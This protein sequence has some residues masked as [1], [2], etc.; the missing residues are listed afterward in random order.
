MTESIKFEI[1]GVPYTSEK[2]NVGRVIDFMKM[3]TA[4]SSGTYGLMYREALKGHDAALVMINCEAFFDVFCPKFV[5]DLKPSSFKDL[6][7]DDYKE[8]KDVYI[9]TIKPW[10]DELEKTLAETNKE[11]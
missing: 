6:G 8:I 9:G 10:I 2:I 4:I 7:L 5:E 11:E 3:K 1:K